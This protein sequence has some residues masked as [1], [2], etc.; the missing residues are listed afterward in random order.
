MKHKILKNIAILSIAFLLAACNGNNPVSNESNSSDDIPSIEIKN[1]WNDNTK[2]SLVNLLGD[3]KFIPF[4]DGFS[5]NY[6]T[7]DEPNNLSNYHT[8]TISGVAKDQ[9]KAI[10]DYKIMVDST[11]LW[12][13]NSESSS[14][15]L[16]Y[17]SLKNVK[18]SYLQFYFDE[19]TFVIQA[20]VLN[21]IPT[22]WSDEQKGLMDKYLGQGIYIPFYY[23]ASSHLEGTE[24]PKVL[25]Y[26]SLTESEDA[27]LEYK[28]YVD[29]IK[30]YVLYESDQIGRA[31]CR[32]RV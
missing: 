2:L 27:V 30:D 9:S 6:L 1:E 5:S 19:T 25:Y 24:S 28:G 8:V 12:N 29:T 4:F 14:A 18:T 17:Y 26:R 31:S 15:D 20:G 21:P 32:E 23:I 16:A 3:I 11:N 13:Y 7:V 10:E 22:D